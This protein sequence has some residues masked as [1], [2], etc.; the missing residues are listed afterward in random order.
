MI[1]RQMI[2]T[3]ALLL[4]VGPAHAASDDDYIT[5]KKQISALRADVMDQGRQ[6]TYLA[7]Q[8][9]EQDRKTA[10]MQ[11]DLGDQK[12]AHAELDEKVSDIEAQRLRTRLA[13]GKWRP[14]TDLAAIVS[15]EVGE[16]MTSL[17]FET[18]KL[19]N[20]DF[21]VTKLA[22]TRERADSPYVGRM[23]WNSAGKQALVRLTA[24]CGTFM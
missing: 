16:T 21:S 6:L 20:E 1:F 12:R 2:L 17:G 24:E 19:E 8:I 14:V 23:T 15:C 4:A 11:I 18:S 22:I 10:T 3:T 9:H 5:L 7:N 13:F